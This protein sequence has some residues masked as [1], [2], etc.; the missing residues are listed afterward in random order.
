MGAVA[1]IQSGLGVEE[2]PVL[3]DVEHVLLDAAVAVLDVF[4]IVSVGT[5][6]HAAVLDV[7]ECTQVGRKAEGGLEEGAA[8][9]LGCVGVVVAVAAAFAEEA[10]G[11]FLIGG[12]DEVAEVVAVEALDAE[13]CDGV[14]ASVVEFE[15]G[16][17][18]EAVLV[19]TFLA[20]E[21]A[22]L[23]LVSGLVGEG[24]DAVFDE[25]VVVAEFFVVAV[26]VGVVADG[27]EVPG[28]AD[29]PCEAEEVVVLPEVV[30]GAGPIEIVGE[31]VA[32][33]GVGGAVDEH[34]LVEGVVLAEA[35]GAEVGVGL[36]AGLGAVGAVHDGEVVGA[37]GDA[38]PG[39]AGILVIPYEFVTYGVV[40]AEPGEGG[41]VASGGAVGAVD[42]AVGDGLVPGA[43]EDEVVAEEAGGEAAAGAPGAEGP[44]GAGDFEG[45]DEGGGFG[46][47]GDRAAE[48]PVT[49]GGGA[50]AALDLDAAEEGGVG[51]HVGPEDGLVF[52]RI[53][54][55]AVEGNVDAGAACSADAHVA[56]A[57]ADTVFA[58]GEDA[59]G[60]GEELGEFPAGVGE[61]VEFF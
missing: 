34:L 56:G 5:V 30:G 2:V 8:V 31:A 14:Q 46:A 48:G 25:F 10:F 45:R 3:V 9:E 13:A 28:G 50:D 32:F 51:V 17:D 43:F 38:V 18:A 11:K 7:A 53:E 41:E 15:V 37:G 61:S 40:E 60:A 24:L 49:V 21:V 42:V 26:A 16:H 4:V 39:L 33:G 55:Y 23:D 20:D 1:E 54:G 12:V 29:F 44:V 6:I 47:E 19:E 22:A 36:D 57:G 59:R 27:G 52:G 58:P 35:F